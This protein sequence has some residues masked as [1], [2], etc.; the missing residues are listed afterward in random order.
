MASADS[1]GSR[2]IVPPSFTGSRRYYVLNYQ[3]TMT[4]Y[5][6]Y[7]PPDLFVTFTCNTKWQEISDA[8]CF[9]PG[10]QPCDRSELVVHIFHMKVSEFMPDIR[11]GATFGLVEREIGSNLFLNDFGG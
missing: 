1:V 9:K 4:I 6:V 7:G 3:D 2:V 11:E 5:R 10:Q 8:L